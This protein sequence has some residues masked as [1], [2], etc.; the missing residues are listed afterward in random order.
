MKTKR[1]QGLVGGWWRAWK[2][3]I[4]LPTGPHKEDG[5]TSENLDDERKSR[6]ADQGMDHRGYGRDQ[7]GPRFVNTLTDFLLLPIVLSPKRP[8]PPLMHP[9]SG[10]RINFKSGYREIVVGRKTKRI[11]K[12]GR[13]IGCC[14]RP[15]PEKWSK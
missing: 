3:M 9:R 14:Q 8:S 7:K 12:E 6:N 5:K 11:T 4:S 15:N 2:Q 1:P 13:F 10:V